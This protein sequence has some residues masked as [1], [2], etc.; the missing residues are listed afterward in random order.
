MKF[1]LF[2]LAMIAGSCSLYAQ[3]SVKFTP[4]GIEAIRSN[5]LQPPAAARPGVYWYFMD[6]NRTRAAMT[7]DLESMKRA[8]IGNVVFLEVNVGVPRGP[9]DLLSDEWKEMFR[10][11]VREGERLGIE[12]TL[13]TGPGWAGSGGPW[14]KPAQSM[15]HL[16]FSVTRLRAAGDEPRAR[17]KIILPVP[18]PKKPY[19]GYGTLTPA[20]R[21]EWEGF[22]EDVA[23]LAFPTKDTGNKIKDIDEKALYYRPPYTSAAGV[24]AFFTPA[25]DYPQLPDGAV[26]PKDQVIDL[27]GKM[28]ADGA[29]NWDAPPGNWTILRCGSRNNGAVTR[30]APVPGL[31]FEVDKMD[32]V[33]LKAHLDKYVGALL[34]RTG[35]PDTSLAGGFK[36]LHI[37]SWEMGAQNWTQHFREEFRKRRGYDP[38]PFYPVYAGNIVGSL[39]I[40]ERFL[41]DLRQTCQELVL[42]YH[43]GQVK[44]YS[45]R[46]GLLLSI[47]PYDMN[48]AADLELGA[49]ADIPMCE[50][51][52]KG[53]GFN[54][55]FSCIEATSIAHVNGISLVP[56]EAF[57][58]DDREGW[59]QFP[60]SMKNQGDWAFATGINRLVFHTFQHQSLDDK[61]R[62]GVTMGPYGVHWNRAQSWWSMADG[63]HRYIT[64]CQYLLQQGRTVADI[65]YLTPEGAPHVFRAPASA[66]DGDAVLPD[67]KGFNFDGCA[68][69]QLYSASVRDGNIVF[70]GGAVYRV[71]VLPASATMTPALL[72][73][74]VA[75]IKAGATVIG[76]PPVHSPGLS[77]FPRCDQRVA[78]LAADWKGKIVPGATDGSLYPAYET[79][80]KI[81]HDMGVAED[82]ASVG[83]LRYT[84]RTGK[85][86]D[87]YFVSNKADSAFSTDV[88]FRV[89]AGTPELWDAVTGTTRPLGEYTV[90]NGH[91]VIPMRFQSY[92]SFFVIFRKGAASGKGKNFPVNHALMTLRGP[93]SVAFDTAWGGPAQVKFDSLYDW[94]ASKVDGIRYYSGEAHYRKTFN[95]PL[96]QNGRI[97][98]DL[99]KVKD[100]ARIKLNGKDLGVVWTAPWR[101][102]ITDVARTRGNQLDITIANRWPNRLI[103]DERLPDDGIKDDKWPEWLLKGQPR[104]SG[105]FTFT[106]YKHYTKDSP[107]LPSGLL[108]PVRILREE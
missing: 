89:D 15:Q 7:A 95:L 92:E 59:K 80:A 86:W 60:G 87:M 13:G 83:P 94:T 5:F 18:A 6:G 40:S 68:P 58:A 42:A 29:L 27:T 52:S 61:F 72:E 88:S 76:A 51:W 105:R 82:F 46:H 37:D 14:V 63:Y 23:V 97:Y 17:D 45:H 32:T 100:M 85:D 74:I 73:K 98:L 25:A 33:S 103:G 20:L 38:L 8:G 36:R 1:L 96:H 49:I 104:T 44:Q 55:S 54:S 77:D 2:L 4:V 67:R 22:Y 21:K 31:G 12:I 34:E 30:P 90:K 39:A 93:W 24:R 78:E 47:E 84:H 70:P 108:G 79:T 35:E 16:V 101:V 43:A 62:P 53:Y 57:T 41:W 81:L 91:A 26:I 69:G 19:F 66:M 107:L 56:A 10:H 106:T 50:F 28:S 11:A 9:V 48:P 102:D 64:R 65:L 3:S 75:L 99:G 71:L